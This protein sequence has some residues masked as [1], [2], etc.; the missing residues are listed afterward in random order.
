MPCSTA[1]RVRKKPPRSAACGTPP[2]CFRTSAGGPIP[3]RGEQSLNVIANAALTGVDHPGRLFLALTTYYRHVGPTD[4]SRDEFTNRLKKLIERRALKRARI[5]G[6]AVRVAHM[7]SIGMA[8]IIDETQLLYEKGKLV[9]VVPQAYAAMNGER[10]AR[11]FQTLGELL[12]RQTEI[13][14]KH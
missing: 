10:L 3:Y 5:I 1:P 12:E 13:R 7:I 9:L 8:G 11:R 6:A 14:L 4:Q 2:A